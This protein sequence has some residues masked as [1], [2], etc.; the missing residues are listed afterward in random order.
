MTTFWRTGHTRFRMG[1]EEYVRGHFV[2]RT[3]WTGLPI[4]L[5]FA[6]SIATMGFA[7]AKQYL[8]PNANCP[9]CGASVYFFRHENGGCAW[10]DAV[11]K[12]WPIHK[13]MES[14][15]GTSSPRLASNSL[16]KP[17]VL[18]QGSPLILKKKAKCSEI[19]IPVSYTHLTLPTKA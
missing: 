12:P 15:R 8:D 18:K 4:N 17:L 13:C 5:R 7:K 10:F 3:R 9:V 16:R 11:G 19:S 2:C 14:F 1:A 6:E